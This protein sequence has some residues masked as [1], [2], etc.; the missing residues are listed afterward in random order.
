MAGFD[1]TK[2]MSDPIALAGL[3]VASGNTLSDALK[4]GAV[5][6]SAYQKQ[7]QEQADYERLR[8]AEAVLPSLLPQIDFSKPNEALSSLLQAGIS[9]EDA[10]KISNQ[11]ADNA[12]LQQLQGL[13]AGGSSG[14][15]VIDDPDR[16]AQIGL[17]TGNPGLIQYAQMKQAQQTKA[18]DRK[19]EET[20]KPLPPEAA[21]AG[22]L[23][24]QGKRA[25]AD[26]AK[27]S[28]VDSGQ[29]KGK[30]DRET[31]AQIFDVPLVGAISLSPKARKLWS[32]AYSAAEAKLRIDSGGAI[33]EEE[34]RKTAKGYLP[35]AIDDADT[36][37]Y[38]IGQLNN[39]FNDYEELTGSRK[40]ATQKLAEEVGIS[41]S[42]VE[43]IPDNQSVLNDL[44][45]P[46]S[47][48]G[49]VAVD[50]QTGQKFRSDGKQWVE[51]K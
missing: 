32:A 6:A 49:K 31:L 41:P 30:V 46:S 1:F 51:V 35:S 14:G 36:V 24:R 26:V 15:N 48:A 11:F 18:A 13:F 27:F 12:R 47:Y 17:L 29:N 21:K 23:V 4:Q 7:Q 25:V 45:D 34:V 19:Y 39:Y 44:P 37:K 22:A 42:E 5:Q 9:L 16:L 20:Q 28:F 43:S 3:G 38:K 50:D 2:L 8:Q 33:T 10:A 40:T